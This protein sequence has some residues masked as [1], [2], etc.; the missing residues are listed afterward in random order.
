MTKGKI[1]GC[2]ACLLEELGLGKKKSSSKAGFKR[3]GEGKIRFPASCSME[4]GSK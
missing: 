3:V 4:Y 2:I 1:Y